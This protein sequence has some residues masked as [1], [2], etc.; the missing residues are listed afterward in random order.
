MRPRAEGENEISGIATG[1]AGES[2]GYVNVEQMYALG[3]PRPDETDPYVKE[4][5]ENAHQGEG[6]ECAPG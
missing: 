3:V 2:E 4:W 5:L 1:R 6:A